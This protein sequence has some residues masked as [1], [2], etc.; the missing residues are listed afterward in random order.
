MNMKQI[1]EQA[2]KGRPALAAM[3]A[4]GR[5]RLAAYIARFPHL[6]GVSFTVR[7]CVRIARRAARTGD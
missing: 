5:L 1:I 3:N 2:R 6:S 4:A 7:E